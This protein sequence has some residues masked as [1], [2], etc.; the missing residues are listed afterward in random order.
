MLGPVVGRS[1]RA[2]VVNSGVELGVVLGGED[3]PGL[4]G[5][6]RLVHILPDGALVQE[7]LQHVDALHLDFLPPLLEGDDG[8]R[9]FCGF[10]GVPFE[11]CTI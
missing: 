11:Q 10:L 2:H 7:V 4:G 3:L 6:F 5:V 9:H 8:H 1:L